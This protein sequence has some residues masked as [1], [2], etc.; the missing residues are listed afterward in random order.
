MFRFKT[1]GK[2]FDV[3]PTTLA[4][5][6]SVSTMIYAIVHFGLKESWPRTGAQHVLSDMSGHDVYVFLQ[7]VENGAVQ[8]LVFGVR[9]RDNFVAR[10]SF[11]A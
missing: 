8:L 11:R 2:V 4:G 10:H 7:P 9:G 6:F 5:L 1:K 3:A